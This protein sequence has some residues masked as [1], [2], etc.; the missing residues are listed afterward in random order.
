VAQDDVLGINIALRKGIQMIALT[1]K[2]YTLDGSEALPI[3]CRFWKGGLD[4]VDPSVLSGPPGND[5]LDTIRQ[6]GFDL[7]NR[8]AIRTNTLRSEWRGHPEGALVVAPSMNLAV[9]ETII[10]SEQRNPGTDG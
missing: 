2:A 9:G 6:L 7:D 3:Q 10:I 4:T 1:F 8:E 5:L